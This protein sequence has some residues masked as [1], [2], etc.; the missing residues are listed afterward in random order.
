MAKHNPFLSAAESARLDS[1][2]VDIAADELGRV[3]ESGDDYRVGANRSLVIH[4][5]GA[6]H[7]FSAGT[8]GRGGVK[9]LQHV[10]K[11]DH[12]Q[13]LGAARE[14]LAD[15]AGYG[16]LIPSSDG[17]DAAQAGDDA[18]RQAFIDTL[19]AAATPAASSTTAKAY[20]A[21]RGLTVS[22]ADMAQLRWIDNVR[23]DE[24]TM[25]VASTDNAGALVAIQETY[26]TPDGW[27]SSTGSAAC[28]HA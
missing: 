27:K 10:R 7:D 3:T 24:G 23:G 28:R 8:G 5:T 15:H 22:A 2:M 13:A 12:E 21:S 17:E 11:L 20:L 9:L 19:W 4:R 26:I 14:W 25:V 18:Q 1:W 16:R 6:F